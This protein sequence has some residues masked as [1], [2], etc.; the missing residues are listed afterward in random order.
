MSQE[1]N[2]INY[3]GFLNRDVVDN[4]LYEL[5]TKLKLMD[6]KLLIRKRVYSASVECLDN[7]YKH[8]YY[9]NNSLEIDKKHLPLF[10]VK[11]TESGYIVESGNLVLKEE[12][13]T[14]KSKLDE[15]NNLEEDGVNELY[16]KT[17]LKSAGLS[18][19]GGAGLGLIVIAKTTAYKLDYS[20]RPVNENY[21]Y[22]RLKININ[23]VTK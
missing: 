8:A 3:H 17:I 2:I 15:L 14:L 11:K 20:I 10:I 13:E 9:K 22:F 6:M 18:D 1:K 19:K 21:S 16:K 5:K 12:G 23:E 4:I 7:I